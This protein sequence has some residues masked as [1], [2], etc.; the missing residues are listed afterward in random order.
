VSTI[1][2]LLP[3]FC[4]L[5]PQ[6]NA[7]YATLSI[8][9]FASEACVDVVKR[10]DKALQKHLHIVEK[11]HQMNTIRCGGGIVVQLLH[12]LY[13][14]VIVASFFHMARSTDAAS[15]VLLSTLLWSS[16]GDDPAG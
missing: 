5:S 6:S 11:P 7:T 10:A 1:T 15:L 3:T 9:K 12:I 14:V 4:K 13:I 8:A 2:P 16:F